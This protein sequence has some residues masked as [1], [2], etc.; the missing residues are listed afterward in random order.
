VLP[1]IKEALLIFRFLCPPKINENITSCHLL[2]SKEHGLILFLE[3][4]TL[5]TP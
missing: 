1:E 5:I 4:S 2:V 3:L